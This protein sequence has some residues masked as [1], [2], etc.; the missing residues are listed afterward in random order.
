MY[1]YSHFSYLPAVNSMSLVLR[2][3]VEPTTVT[4]AV[5]GVLS[6]L[7]PDQPVFRVK[8]MEQVVEDSVAGTRLLMRL[9]TIFGLLAL[10]LAVVGVY[11]VM[12]YVVSQR[13]HEIGI[14]M[15]LGAGS[16]S[17][18]RMMLRHCLVHALA[19]SLV[20]L[21]TA[22]G[23]SRVIGRFVIGIES[24]DPATY[25][26]ATAA[27]V[28]VAL[29]AA[30]IPARRASRVDPL[31]ALR[32]VRHDPEWGRAPQVAGAVR[33]QIERPQ[34]HLGEKQRCCRRRDP[35]VRV[36]PVRKQGL[37]ERESAGELEGSETS[38][39]AG[40]AEVQPLA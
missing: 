6:E 28:A 22:V 18:V 10:L 3:A 9:L 37:H 8:T 33:E 12:S 32:G 34:A 11:G 24:T 13:V 4:G 17:I 38:G 19:G 25:A 21:L 39:H 14:R 1:P 36:R 40:P 30:F 5:R 20:G 23:L 31:S 2:T 7:D 15:A 26:V 29:S 35:L 16:G 27:V